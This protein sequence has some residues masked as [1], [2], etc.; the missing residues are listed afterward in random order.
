[1]GH[2]TNQLTNNVNVVHFMNIP[3]FETLLCVVELSWIGIL[4]KR[5]TSPLQSFFRNFLCNVTCLRFYRTRKN[6]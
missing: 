3:S 2:P 6:D 1:L 5:V 4:V